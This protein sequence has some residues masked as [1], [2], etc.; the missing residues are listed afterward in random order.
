MI[1]YTDMSA[2]ELV[3][4]L[5]N[6]GEKVELGLIRALVEK[7]EDAAVLLRQA[8]ADEENWYEGRYGKYWI[9]QHAL[10]VL[11]LMKD[12]KSLP[13]IFEMLPHAYF[14]D[15]E[16]AIETYIAAIANFGSPAVPYCL[17]FISELRGAYHD[18]PDYSYCRYKALLALTLIARTDDSVRERVAQFIYRLYEGAAE[19]DDTFLSFSVPCPVALDTKRGFEVLNAACQRD[20]LDYSICGTYEQMRDYWRRSKT[21]FMR[22]LNEPSNRIEY[23]YQPEKIAEKV[24]AMEKSEEEKLY[25]GVPDVEVPAGF[26]FTEAGTLV[27]P[28]KVGRNDPCTCGSGKKYK[29][30]C[31]AG[32]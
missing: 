18:N 1:R 12:E 5:Y 6:E 22:D 2:A 11:S 15:H 23:F 4:Q 26:Q 29:K 19:D 32:G 14:A 25:W 7:G 17:D 28:V 10:A 21:D 30:C 9:I 27:N 3:G 16:A 13:L 8:L 31:G 24:K 20:A